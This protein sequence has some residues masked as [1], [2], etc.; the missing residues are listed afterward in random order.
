MD[1]DELIDLIDDSIAQQFEIDESYHTIEFISQ[2]IPNAETA[3]ILLENYKD[4]IL[5]SDSF[6]YP[7]DFILKFLQKI[8]SNRK[9]ENVLDPNAHIGEMLYLTHEM[10]PNVR[11]RGYNFDQNVIDFNFIVQAD[12]DQ[13]PGNLFE[14]LDQEK[15]KYDLIITG[16]YKLPNFSKEQDGL[17]ICTEKKDFIFECLSV[18][19]D[20]GLFI[21]GIIPQI[22]DKAAINKFNSDLVE[23]GFYI[24][25]LFST[26]EGSVYRSLPNKKFYIIVIEKGKQDLTFLAEI[27][28][29]KEKQSRT[30]I[31]YINRK[32][33]DNLY[34]GILLPIDKIEPID[35]II[36]KREINLLLKKPGLPIIPLKHL[37]EFKSLKDVENDWLIIPKGTIIGLKNVSLGYSKEDIDEKSNYFF[38]INTNKIE[39]IYL[40]EF[41]NSYIGKA[42]LHL[43]AVKD[44]IFKTLKKKDL[45]ELQIPVDTIQSQRKIIEI[46]RVIQNTDEQFRNFRFRLWNSPTDKSIIEKKINQ[47]LKN[48]ENIEWMEELPFPLASILWGYHSESTISKK[49]EYMFLFFEGLSEFLDTILLSV[50]SKDKSL[51]DTKFKFWLKNDK[52]PDWYKKASFGGWQKLHDNLSYK[53]KTLQSTKDG[54][55]LIADLFPGVDEG[56]LKMILSSEIKSTF[57]NLNKLRND[58]KGHGGITSEEKSKEVLSLLETRFFNIKEILVSGFSNFK[59]LFPVPKTSGWDNES[60]IYTTTC[61]LLNGT[62]SKFKQIEVQ[63]NKPLSSNELYLLHENQFTPIKLLPLVQMRESPKTGQDACYFYNSIKNNQVRL[64]SYHFEK[65]AELFDPIER[66]LNVFNILEPFGK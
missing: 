2:F 20:D 8:I 60:E 21:S 10:F 43:I 32:N 14:L 47:L 40:K 65:E 33:S 36:K 25:A 22:F 26:P 37:G 4:L 64:V 15:T 44:P 53:I 54:K 24:K 6:P 5:D 28:N 56:F 19:K 62:R 41:L 49:V 12:F 52:M 50:L 16:F 38:E 57:I 51:F 23:K 63:T 7:N 66:Y 1:A 34:E 18:L 59:L 9:I 48:P 55:E 58:F 27:S 61:K 29:N 17:S 11:M 46:D 3:K 13:I 31:N 45:E 30:I 35:E 39:S 42:L